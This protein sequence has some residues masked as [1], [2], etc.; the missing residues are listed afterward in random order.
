MDYFCFQIELVL[1]ESEN[2]T[3]AVHEE[4]IKEICVCG[5][6]SSSV[7]FEIIPDIIGLMPIEGI[8]FTFHV[9]HFHIF[10]VSIFFTYI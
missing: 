5:S 9:L 2:F 7:E 10:H 6:Q 8:I 3:L 1:S 4:R